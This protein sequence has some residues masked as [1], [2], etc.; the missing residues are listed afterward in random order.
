MEVAPTHSKSQPVSKVSVVNDDAFQHH[1]QM[2]RYRL[3][4]HL[5]RRLGQRKPPPPKSPS[6]PK[7]IDKESRLANNITRSRP[8]PN[9]AD[10]PLRTRQ[11]VPLFPT[12]SQGDNRLQTPPPSTSRGR[13]SPKPLMPECQG[14]PGRTD[15]ELVDS[16]LKSMIQRAKA[17][18]ESEAANALPQG[19]RTIWVPVQVADY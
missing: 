12:K 2:L 18:L 8:R 4:A 5:G 10:I 16:V 14:R 9:R 11:P 1:R 19:T 15:A 17:Q 3:K 13:Y 7:R 6:P